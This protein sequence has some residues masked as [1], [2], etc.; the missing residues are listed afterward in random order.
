MS[1]VEVGE[2]I[3]FENG[4]ID[5]VFPELKSFI[6]EHE[7]YREKNLVEFLGRIKHSKQII[8]LIE[9]GDFVN[10]KLIYKIDKGK[11]YCY[12]YYE[13][14]KTFVD[15]QIEEILTKEQYMENCFKVGGKDE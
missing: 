7:S 4:K 8:D 14:G 5:V 10:G 3:R 1:K 6:D 9:V 13:N 12:L 2:Y 15:Y 11:N